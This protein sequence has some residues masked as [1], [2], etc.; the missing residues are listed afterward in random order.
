MNLIDM[1]FSLLIKNSFNF[2]FVNSIKRTFPK[3]FIR[4]DNNLAAEAQIPTNNDQTEGK[5]KRQLKREKKFQDI[6][7]RKRLLKQR[8]E[9]TK[10][11][12]NVGYTGDLIAHT[13]YYF[14]NGL[15]KVKVN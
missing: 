8:R 10:S 1:T 11:K 14:E 4:M 3:N 12:K 15:R 5:S 2:N 6:E 13:D 7:E 9:E